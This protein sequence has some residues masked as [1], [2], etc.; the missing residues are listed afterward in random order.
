MG[1]DLASRAVGDESNSFRFILVLAGPPNDKRGRL[2]SG[3]P[4]WS[5]RP[6]RPAAHGGPSGPSGPLL[7]AINIR[8]PTIPHSIYTIVNT[9]HLYIVMSPHPHIYPLYSYLHVWVYDTCASARASRMY[10]VR[11]A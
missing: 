2:E 7:I 10:K 6:E 5:E 9:L 11:L 3:S 8:F 1:I 4:G